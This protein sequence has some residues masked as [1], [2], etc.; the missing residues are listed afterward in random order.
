MNKKVIVITII[1]L[2]IFWVIQVQFHKF[3]SVQARNKDMPS[4]EQKIKSLKPGDIE[5]L[6]KMA[7]M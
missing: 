7:G 6:K 1:C 4:I 5:K 3:T 2:L